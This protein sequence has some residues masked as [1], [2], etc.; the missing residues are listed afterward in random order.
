MLKIFTK[1]TLLSKVHSM[2]HTETITRKIIIF[3]ITLNKRKTVKK[4]S[5]SPSKLCGSN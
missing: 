2:L 5:I 3:Q 4:T 1:I